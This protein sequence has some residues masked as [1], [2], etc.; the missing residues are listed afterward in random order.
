MNLRN[1]INKGWKKPAEF[2]PIR[3]S[4]SVRLW[5]IGDVGY[6]R[7]SPM[8][9]PLAWLK[10]RIQTAQQDDVLILLGDLLYPAGLPHSLDPTRSLAEKRLRMLIEI[11]RSF[12]GQCLWLTGNHDWLSGRPEGALAVQELQKFLQQE[13]GHSDWLFPTNPLEPG[14]EVLEVTPFLTVAG[15]NTQHFFQPRPGL[16]LAGLAAQPGTDKA[17][18]ARLLTALE[19]YSDRVVVVVGHHP[20]FSYGPHGN[21]YHPLHHLFPLYITRGRHAPPIPGPLLATLYIENRKR[22]G[23]PEDFE[24]PYYRHFRDWM[25]T[26]LENRNV[27]YAAG[28][29]HSLQVIRKN[30]FVQLVSGGGSAAM[31][32]RKGDG[33]L[34]AKA[35]KGFQELTVNPNHT[36]DLIVWTVGRKPKGK[37]AWSGRLLP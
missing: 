5:L 14:P 31:Y 9:P 4:G 32:V 25:L 19:T 13:V 21:C 17:F 27:I 24:H 18:F 22:G 11:C 10:E 35:A 7:L 16:E 1:L 20:V 36:A 15:L 23:S 2:E 6:A 8:E 12:A 37:R 34:F 29:E 30:G 3:L 28:H 26:V 33:T